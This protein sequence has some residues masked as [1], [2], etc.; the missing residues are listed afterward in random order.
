MSAA[1]LILAAGRGAR[2]AAGGGTE[3][4]KLLALWRGKPLVRHVAEAALA[5]R[6]RPVVVVTGHARS[7]I[8][9]ALAGLDLTFAH[10][11]AFADGLAGS[12]ACGLAAL[13]GDADS[14][15]ILLADMPDIHAA[16]I[17]RLTGALSANPKAAAAAPLYQGARGN[18]VALARRL[19]AQAASLQGDQGARKIL[20]SLGDGLIEVAVDDA[21]VT[22]DIDM[23]ETLSALKRGE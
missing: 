11:A 22:L 5:S 2:F 13:P 1:A 21:G 12:L 18:P 10:N 23:P 14:A 7:E 15:V 17:D 20:D 16:L 19:F 8:E 3:P 4:S 9:A 6:A